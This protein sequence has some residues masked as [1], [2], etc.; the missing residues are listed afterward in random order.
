MKAAFLPSLDNQVVSKPLLKWAGGKTQLL[1]EIIPKIPQNY[2]R[3]IEPFFGGGAVFF[4]LRPEK[5]IIADNN[6]ELINLYRTVA[7]NVD[8]V[9]AQ[10]RHYENTEESF[11]AVRAQDWTKLSCT[12][13]SAR[14][15]FLNK[16]CY[17]GLYRVNK[18]GQFNVPFGGYK[19][20]KI[21]DEVSLFAA[22]AILRK[23]TIICGDYKRVLQ[24]NAQ[25]GDFIFL[26]PP[27]SANL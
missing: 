13:A 14:T 25:P 22:S 15:I 7:D 11:Y 6:P 19:N 8:G 10:L 17:N 21:T 23:S 9:I 16:T 2:S 27:L 26:D 5:A 12:E 1:G 18:S 4:S 20:P 24:E 3:Y